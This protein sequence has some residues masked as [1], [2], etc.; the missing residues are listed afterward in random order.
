LGEG[1][2]QTEPLL[3][4]ALVP[5]EV[6]RAQYGAITDLL[7][8]VGV[9]SVQEMLVGLT[10]ARTEAV[11]DG[12]DPAV[13]IRL[14]CVP[15]EADEP[16]ETTHATPFSRVRSS[17]I[18]WILDGKAVE[19]SAALRLPWADAPGTGRFNGLDPA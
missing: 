12:L 6:L 14:I 1:Q 4:R 5:D 11:F 10:R 16:C 3:I 8:Q 9:T 7:A 17:G 18:K 13:R 15:L 19:R 2:R